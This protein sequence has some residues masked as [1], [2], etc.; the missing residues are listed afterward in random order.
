MFITCVKVSKLCIRNDFNTPYEL[1]LS[2]LNLSLI[3]IPQI[4][5]I[6]KKKRIC[7][8]F[9]LGAI[10]LTISFNRLKTLKKYFLI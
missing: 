8:T 7:L 4:I 10:F 9:R 5:L 6:I 1:L 3:I 2:F